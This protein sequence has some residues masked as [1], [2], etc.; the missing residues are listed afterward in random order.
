MA[1]VVTVYTSSRDEW[2]LRDM[3]RIR[4][5]KISEALARQGNQ[6][7]IATGEARFKQDPT[8]VIMGPGLR[9]IPLQ[10]LVWRE[11][12]VVK[13]L[14]HLGFETLKEFGGTHHPLIISKLGSVVGAEDLPGIYFYGAMRKRLYAT[15]RE[16]NRTSRYIT[17]LSPAARD[18]WLQVHGRSHRM[19]L[20]PGGVDDEIPEPK[21][22]PYQGIGENICIF[23]GN[24][25]N[26]DSQ[27]EANRVLVDKLNRLGSHL[28]GTGVRLCFQGL[29]NTEGLDDRFVRNLG[30]CSL[31]DSWNYL[32]HASAGVVVSAGPFM[33]NN[34]STK[35]Y[36]Y[37][38]A[39]LPVVSEQGFPNDY[40]VHESQCGFV[41][42]GEDMNEMAAKVLE[43]CRTHWDRAR[44][45]EYVRANHTWD[46]RARVYKDVIGKRSES[47]LDRALR[48]CGF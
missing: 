46:C 17:V 25:Y 19:L 36:H 12:D 34:E 14:F 21:A 11:Y 7:D 45:I 35:I 27:P 5:Q 40:V 38:R 26:A 16:I 2:D 24:I 1:R 10:S 48:I 33:H 15:Q 3:S 44:A 31:A 4:W 28:H 32:Q 39:G 47:L 22:N 42:P 41:V 20:V 18:L 9:R 29:G 6:V 43:A 13:T 30:S 23:S 37:L 8:P